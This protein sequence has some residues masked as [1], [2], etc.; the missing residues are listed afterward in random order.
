MMAN[1]ASGLPSKEAVD[2]RRVD[3]YDAEATTRETKPTGW[4]AW[5]GGPTV[6]IGPRIAPVVAPLNANINTSDSEI[7]SK[8]I[9]MK[10][11]ESEENSAIQYRTCS[12]QKVRPIQAF[13]WSMLR[14]Q[15]RHGTALTWL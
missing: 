7:D 2:E 10:Q 9:L 12:W 6:K 14:R 8:D 3:G 15:P 13:L 4:A 1:S 5:F 11:I